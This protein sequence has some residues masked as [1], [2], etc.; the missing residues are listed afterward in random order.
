VPA[1]LA[2]PAA[3]DSALGGPADISLHI[4]PV[5]F[6]VAKGRT[7]RTVAY[8]GTVPGPLIR[9]REG[10]PATVDIVNETGETEYVHW[11]GFHVPAEVDG[12]AEEGSLSVPA[13]GKLRYRI[14]PLP[15]GT[16][17]VHT[18]AM[19]MNNLDRGPF[20]GQFAFVYIQPRSDPGRY[21]QEVFLATHEWEPRLIKGEEDDD[22]SPPAQ[23][24]APKKKEGHQHGFEVAYRYYT[25]NG[26]CLGFGDPVRVKEGER[27]LFHFLNASATASVRFALP[28][29]RFQVVALDGNPVPHP[30]T[31]DVL[32]L[33]TAE[34]VDAVV[35]MDNP[36]VWSLSTPNESHRAKGMGIV[37]E[38]AN[39]TGKPRWVAPAATPWDYTVFA[40]GRPAP[41]PD[42]IIPLVIEQGRLTLEGFDEWRINGKPYDPKASPIRLVKG[43]RN[44]L[45]F[46]NQTDDPHPVHLHRS[47]FE[48][49]DVIGKPVSGVIKDVV[50]VKSNQKLAV[51]VIPSMTGPA[52]FH[53]HQQLHMDYGFKLLF[54]IV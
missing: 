45:V 20:T 8:N 26:K 23:T 31:V 54:D 13:N 29:H 50:Q 27:V 38:Y 37:V 3:D 2:A 36:G 7:I 48:L 24:S 28:G 40:D 33:G 9:F 19:S 11:H 30:Q 39:R 46:D 21:D 43:K 1:A 6:E 35:T 22:S 49:V 41:K 4:G 32:E 14:T 44:R 52:L 16:K 34:R 10:V 17:Y 25:I 5:Q 47:S 53:C 15:S 12:A 51:D 42:A 18:H